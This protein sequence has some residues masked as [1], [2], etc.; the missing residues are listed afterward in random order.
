MISLIKGTIEEKRKNSL[1]ILT[2]GGVGYE[3]FLPPLKLAKFLSGTPI[4]LLTYLKVSDSAL[5]L[6]GFETSDEREFFMLLLTVSGIGPKSAMTIL[7]LGSINE[8]QDAIGRGDVKYLTAV[9]G[10]GKKTAERLVVELKTKVMDHGTRS[11]EQIDSGSLGE[12]V[13]AL[14]A[15]GYSVD[16]AR[17]TVRDLI[18]EV[19]EDSQKLLK[20]ALQ[21]L[22]R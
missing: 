5:D 16:E 6:Y 3:V 12:V 19:G 13:D 17:G 1:V 4:K 21:R 7:S 15:M 9:Q 10:M 20:K 18:G 2:A 22:A 11:M 8:I 14:V